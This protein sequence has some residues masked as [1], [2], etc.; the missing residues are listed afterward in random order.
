[1]RWRRLVLCG[2]AALFSGCVTTKAVLPDQSIPHRLAA[3]VKGVTLW[4][5]DPTGGLRKCKADL[6]EGWWVASPLVVEEPV[7]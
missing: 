3:P 1:M 5:A 4:C 2:S 6:P 7:K